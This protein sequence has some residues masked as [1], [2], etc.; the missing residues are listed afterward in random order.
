[1]HDLED[2]APVEQLDNRREVPLLE[3]PQVRRRVHP[4]LL[5]RDGVVGC[6]ARRYV[7]IARQP[8]L[9]RRPSGQLPRC[10][11]GRAARQMPP[12]QRT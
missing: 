10:T 11:A 3:L 12:R 4:Q 9:E 5:E 2:A 6:V 1:M 7:A 8:V